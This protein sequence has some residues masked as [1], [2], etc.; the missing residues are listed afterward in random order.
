MGFPLIMHLHFKKWNIDYFAIFV[1]SLLVFYGIFHH[2][3]WMDESHHWLVAR[4][5]VYLT[6]LF[7][8]YRYD[9]H[10]ILWG[11]LMW[12]TGKF[13]SNLFAVPNPSCMHSH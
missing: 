13:T 1:Y 8:N 11:V 7:E 4:A 10:P 12:I 6:D 9:G 5:S 2:E 3:M